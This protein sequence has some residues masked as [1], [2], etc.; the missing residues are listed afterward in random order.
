[1][2]IYFLPGKL[3]GPFFLHNNLNITGT[4]GYQFGSL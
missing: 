3:G 4:L 1:M 2:K